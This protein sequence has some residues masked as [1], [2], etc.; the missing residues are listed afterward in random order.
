MDFSQ[1][2]SKLSKEDKV[3]M[4]ME[5]KRLLDNDLIKTFFREAQANLF[6]RWQMDCTEDGE[7]STPEYRETIYLQLQALKAFQ[8]FFQTCLTTQRMVERD[9]ADNEAR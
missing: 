8:Q 9:V 2:P 5:A 1:Q 6:R 3:L 7:P 4:G